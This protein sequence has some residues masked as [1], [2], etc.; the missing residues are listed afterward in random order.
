MCVL[1][2]LKDALRLYEPSIAASKDLIV[3]KGRSIRGLVG[4]DR[5]GSAVQVLATTCAWSGWRYLTYDVA[6]CIAVFKIA[7]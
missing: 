1:P 2:A 7:D 5:S 3:S 6:L 4:F